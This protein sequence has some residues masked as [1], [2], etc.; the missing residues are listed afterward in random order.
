MSPTDDVPHLVRFVKMMA[1]RGRLAI[2]GLLAFKP[3]TLD[4]LGEELSNVSRATLERNL[5]LLEDAE[6]IASEPGGKYRL[7]TDS[8]TTLRAAVAR[9]EANPAPSAAASVAPSATPASDEPSQAVLHA[10][11]DDQGR[12]RR[13]PTQRRQREIVLSHITERLFSL[14]RTYDEQ[15]VDDLLKP[16]YEDYRNLRRALVAEGALVNR[17]D[18]YWLS[19]RR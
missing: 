8:L 18:R 4:E 19:L 9:V 7:R 3:H 13:L 6:W 5:K 17:N 2:I 15:E 11:F 14:G 16:V 12:L 1:D 10:F